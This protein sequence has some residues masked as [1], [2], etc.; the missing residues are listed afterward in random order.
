MPGRNALRDLALTIFVLVVA[1]AGCSGKPAPAEAA[2]TI[3]VNGGIYTVDR[4]RSWAQAAA[5]RDGRIVAVGSN[6]EVLALKGD[7]TEVVDLTGRMAL[8]GFHDSHV[9]V[10][11]A[12]LEELQCPLTDQRTVDAIL[13]AVKA[14]AERSE[15]E[16]IVGSGWD[17]SLFE[18]SSP[19]K[20]LLDRIAPGR[21]IVLWGADGHSAWASS[22]ALTLAGITARTPNP[23]NGVIEHDRRTGE[24]SGTLRETAIDLVMDKVPPPRPE[25]RIEGLK[26]GLES[27]REVGITSFIEA[28]VG[29]AD[30]EA[31]KAVA[32][33]GELTAKVRLSM[34]YGMFGADDFE[35]LLAR[36]AQA[37]GPRLK[38]DA[39]KI[40][41][42]GVLEGE[43]AALLSPY[44]TKPGHTGDI[45]MPAAD[46]NTAVTRFDAMGLQVHMHAIGDAAV[47]AGLDAIAAARA[48][49]GPGDHRHHI[50]HLQLIDPADIPRFRALGVTAN[51]QSF[52]AW[53]DDY[54][55]RLN[56]PQVGADRVNR[57]Y[58]IASVQRAGGRI[59]GGS[60]WSVS[61][62][63]PLPAIQVAMTR[64]DPDGVRTE[65]LNEAE[66]VDLPTM[67]AAYT[68]DGAWLMHHETDTGSIETGKAAD[69]VVLEKDLF[70]V[71][72]REIGGVRVDL[73]MLDGQVLYRRSDAERPPSPA[74]TVP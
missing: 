54:I 49:N 4:G 63:N 44:L 37:S 36:R 12:G 1:A 25:M 15:E 10:A 52:W 9:H 17:L 66:R 38:A 67:I 30:F 5:V 47:R 21:A 56:L 7:A 60:D 18:N 64:Q 20:E 22:R 69:I 70:K 8:P 28:S 32:Q 40:F 19:R 73:T 35:A 72:P 58:P 27:L 50:A 34:T 57:M 23:E 16:W 68:I 48:R 42:D 71:A 2:D 41:V 65:V 45:T 24:P 59:V 53:P 43:T 14:C 29:E 61:T 62:V 26:R 33:R 51:F 39:I 13:E 3:F 46:L 55:L 74:G 31:F 6:E 11:A